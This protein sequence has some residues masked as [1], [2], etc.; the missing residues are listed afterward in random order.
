MT[1]RTPSLTLPRGQRWP[2]GR[3]RSVALVGCGRWG[4]FILRD[5]VALDAEV[6]VADP[7]PSARAGALAAGAAAT[8]EQ[9]DALPPVAGVI[10]ATPTT[11]HALVLEALLPRGVPLFC[12]KPLTADPAAAE[13][14]AALAASRLFV[15]DKWRYH[16]GIEA[17][18]ELGASGT[19]G[20]IVGLRTL[21]H[22]WDAPHQDVDAVWILAPHD[23]AIALEVL[24]HLPTPRSA[25]AAHVAG[26]AAGLT[27]VL[28][29]DPWLELDVSVARAGKRREVRLECERGAAM[30]AD[31][32]SDHLRIE[33]RHG[34]GRPASVEQR[35]L[36]T[37]L[38]LRRE[39]RAFLDHLTGGPPPKSSAAEG[40]AIVRTLASLRE[41]A[42]LK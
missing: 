41:L 17:L 12:E 16:P 8:V 33:R 20:R 19:L 24:G 38:P 4:Q 37:E 40:A 28:G 36:S 11:A 13:R 25:V 15:M 27:A 31:A 32:Y 1:T 21:R 22:G 42:G 3:G 34:D 29:G 39:L 18:R 7:A 26:G 10:V 6:I 23:L 9:V 5:L 14:L 35:A 30:L 2:R